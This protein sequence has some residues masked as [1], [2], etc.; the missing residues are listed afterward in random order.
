MIVGEAHG[1][2]A[3]V[4]GDPGSEG[5]VDRNL[6]VVGAQTVAVGVGVGEE[7]ALHITH[8]HIHNEDV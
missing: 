1:T 5:T 6:Q 2:I 4:V 3:L 7:A 8:T